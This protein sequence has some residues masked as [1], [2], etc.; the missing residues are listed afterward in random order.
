MKSYIIT[1]C[2]L[3]Q[4]FFNIF[5]P[6][7]KAS[8]AA[9]SFVKAE[10]N[11]YQQVACMQVCEKEICFSLFSTM[12]GM[13]LTYSFMWQE[14]LSYLVLDRKFGIKYQRRKKKMPPEPTANQDI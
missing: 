4:N 1:Y 3:L 2:L 8:A 12:Q 10:G 5:K 13:T 6:H 7:E 14:F 9:V 11:F